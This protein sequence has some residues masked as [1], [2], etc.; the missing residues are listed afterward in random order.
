MIAAGLRRTVEATVLGLGLAGVAH[1]ADLA[2]ARAALLAGQHDAAASGLHSILQLEPRNAEAHL[3]L[4]R[5]ELAAANAD[6]AAAECDS[7]LTDGLE[8]AS[9]AQD[10]AG[11]ALGSKAAKANPLSAFALARRVRTA[12]EEAV[13]LEPAS[14]A[15]LND[16]T[17]FYVQAPAIVGGGLEK[18]A[19]LADRSA[20]VNA[21]AAHRT[22]ALL[23]QKRGDTATAEREFRAA[24][25]VSHHPAAMVDLAIFLRSTGR[26]DAAAAAASVAAAADKPR[27]AASVDAATLLLGLNRNVAEA[28]GWLQ[29]YLAS[30]GRSDDAPA[31]R[32]EVQVGDAL[33]RAGNAK[34]AREAYLAA[35][36]LYADYDPAKQALRRL[37]GGGA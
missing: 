36:R 9:S 12:F 21:A 28:V 4:C 16:L 35:L 22:R 2:A 5:V 3:L 37:P 8:D 14:T 29:E 32:V 31:Y 17:D 34:G 33:A 15:A 11:R 1:A 19:A 10:W 30:A 18:A 7:A 26:P 20:T 25:D 27:T 13:A 23:A 24:I 6:A